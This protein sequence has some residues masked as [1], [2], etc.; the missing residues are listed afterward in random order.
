MVCFLYPMLHKR[1]WFKPFT[2]TVLGEGPDFCTKCSWIH[3]EQP[4]MQTTNECACIC[5]LWGKELS[6]SKDTACFQHSTRKHL[7]YVSRDKGCLTLRLPGDPSQKCWLKESEN[8]P[9]ILFFEI[10]EFITPHKAGRDQASRLPLRDIKALGG[11]PSLM[12]VIWKAER[13]SPLEVS[14]NT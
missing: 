12:T 8:V 10:M 3:N 13:S 4:Q 11:W 6:F 14:S 1:D 7:R 5:L 2:V 9:I